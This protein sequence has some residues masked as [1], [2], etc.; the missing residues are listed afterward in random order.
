MI[1]PSLFLLSGTRAFPGR[2]TQLLYAL[3]PLWD[4]LFLS[5]FIF[6]GFCMRGE[7]KHVSGGTGNRL[8]SLCFRALQVLVS[9]RA[10]PSA[11]LQLNELL[12]Y[13][14]RNRS[15]PGFIQT[16]ELICI[17]KRRKRW[18]G[19][20]LSKWIFFQY[21]LAVVFVHTGVDSPFSTPTQ[22]E[23][24]NIHRKNKFF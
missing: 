16:V 8:R 19:K 21:L 22:V 23:I 17:A 4:A 13:V 14:V 11:E 3:A 9:P 15:T 2:Q 6:P 5:L 18:W 10:L 20:C 12:H 1:L 7:T 24:L